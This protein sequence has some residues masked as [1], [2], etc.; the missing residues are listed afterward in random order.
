MMGIGQGCRTYGTRAQNDI[1]EDFL[2][3]LPLLLPHF[4]SFA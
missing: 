4:I 1:W 2:D 3:T